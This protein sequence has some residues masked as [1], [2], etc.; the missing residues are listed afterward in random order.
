M[1]SILT[2]VSYGSLNCSGSELK[3]GMGEG[4][5]TL[6]VGEFKEDLGGIL[7]IC[8]QGVEG[9]PLLEGVPDVPRPISGG[10]FSIRHALVDVC[11]PRMETL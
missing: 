9:H 11:Y 4:A 7:V 1:E 8:E 6:V 2:N 5:I 10:V 3:L